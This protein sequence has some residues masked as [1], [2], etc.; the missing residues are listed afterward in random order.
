MSV[1]TGRFPLTFSLLVS[2]AGGVFAQHSAVVSL[3]DS[4]AAAGTQVVW[5]KKVPRYCEGP[6]TDPADG[7]VYWS[8]Q[9]EGSTNDWPIWKMNPGNPSDTGSRWITASNQTN[10]LFVDSQ[11]RV[12]AAQKGKIVR[13]AK[14]GAQD[15][16]LATSGGSVTFNQ[17]NDLSVG[18]NGAIYFTDL[19]SQVY[20]LDATRKLK[21]AATGLQGANGVEWIEEQ[22][23]VYVL[24]ANGN[25]ITRFTVG[26]DGSLTNPQP[27]RTMPIPDGADLDSHGNWYVGS[28]GDGAV[29]VLN[30]K[31]DSIGRITFNMDA[32]QYNPSSGK[33]GNIDNCHFGGA[34][35]K[36]LYC[37]GD[38]GLF[39]IN[40]KI[41]GRVWAAS[42]TTGIHS[43]GRAATP[44]ADAGKTYRADGRMLT[45]KDGM[46]GKSGMDSGIPLKAP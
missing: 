19:G 12:L 11:G 14:S 41:P 25:K 1:P 3:P 18:A 27:F 32:G 17:A 31:G 16:V 15:S 33:Q 20:F 21:V 43:S 2:L 28:Y 4:I 8:E 37:T 24:E 45:E 23:A 5:V 10:G 22:N 38:G 40:L 7:T 34:G 30:A 39:S 29:H 44:K 46:P 13:Y 42:V 36:T 26:S 6:A 9:R 35:N